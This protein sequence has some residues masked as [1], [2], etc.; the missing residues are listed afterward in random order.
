M[1]CSVEKAVA[2]ELLHEMDDIALNEDE[3]DI[4][5]DV[6]EGNKDKQEDFYYV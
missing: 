6:F 5:M 1:M 3:A 2:S 4:A